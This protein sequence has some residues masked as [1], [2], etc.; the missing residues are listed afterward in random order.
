VVIAIIGILAAMVF[1]VFARAR[2]SARKAVCLSNVKNIALAINMYLNDYDRF[3]PDETR[4][5]VI[6]FFYSVDGVDGPGGC[7]VCNDNQTCESIGRPMD[8][9]PFLRVP[10]ILDEYV[11]N[12]DVWRCPSAKTSKGATVIIPDYYP[13]GWL[14]YFQSTIGQWG[15]VQGQNLGPCNPTWPPGWGGQVTDSILQQRKAEW[16]GEA[17]GCFFQEIDVNLGKATA[18]KSL[19]T[20]DDTVKYVAV[21]DAGFHSPVP[22][23]TLRLAYP[24]VNDPGSYMCGGGGDWENCSFTRDCSI[25]TGDYAK[26][27][28]SDPG[29]RAKFT[30]H[31]GGSN[32]GFL[33]GHAK[34]YQAEAIIA[35]APIYKG[36]CWCGPI[37]YRG[38]EGIEP[39]GPTLSE[40]GTD[41]GFCCCTP[42]FF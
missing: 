25:G 38:L 35:Q 10:V 30:R 20:I 18:G 33:D 19:S 42:P 31:L 28:A 6:D 14:G 17:Y 23:T 2:E 36:G 39:D 32:I 12:R 21:M 11:K 41:P 24:D 8:A 7:G 9:N 1:P 5:E 26:Q 34:W 13:G 16:D 15:R 3:F 22:I 37:V 29:Y 40:T 27:F 4:S